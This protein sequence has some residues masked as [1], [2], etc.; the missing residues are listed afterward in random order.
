MTNNIFSGIDIH[1][2]HMIVTQV[3]V[4]ICGKLGQVGPQTYFETYQDVW[5]KFFPAS[6][7]KTADEIRELNNAQQRQNAYNK[8]A[9]ANRDTLG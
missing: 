5:N 8:N 7:P 9:W 1:S 6:K 4:A 3:T 2:Q